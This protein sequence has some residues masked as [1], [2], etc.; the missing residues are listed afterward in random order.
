MAKQGISTG[1]TPNDGTGDSL[2]SGAVKINSNFDEIYTAIGDG[3]TLSPVT[4]IVAGDNISVSGSTG[5]VTITGIGTADIDTDKINV[6][7]ISTFGT[8]QISSGIVTAKSGI[9]TYYGDGSGLTGVAS[10]DY[11]ITGTAATFNNAVKVG[12][13]VTIDATSGIVTATSFSGSGIGLTGLPAGQLTGSLPAIDGSALTGVTAVGSGI[14]VRDSGTPIGAASTVDFGTGLSVSPVSS[15]IV[16]VTSSAGA[17][18]TANINSDTIVV[19]VLTATTFAGDLTLNTGDLLLSAGG[20]SAT[21][22]SENLNWGSGNFYFN[23]GTPELAWV[24]NSGNIRAGAGGAGSG[25]VSIK[26]GNPGENSGVFREGGA[27]ELYYDNSKKFET[28]G[29]GVTVLGT[30]DTQQLNVAGVSTFSGDIK[31]DGSNIVLGV[32]GGATDDRIVLGSSPGYLQIYNASGASSVIDGGSANIINKTPD[33]QVQN[34]G[35]DLMLQAANA[36]SVDLYYNGSKKFETTGAGVS[37]T[38][39][40]YA[41]GISTFIG[42]VIIGRT[43][44]EG[45]GM[46]LDGGGDDGGSINFTGPNS[47]DSNETYYPNISLNKSS[48]NFK[49]DLE[50][51]TNGYTGIGNGVGDFIF[52]KRETSSGRAERMRLEGETGNLTITGATGGGIC[53]ATSFYG[54]GS[55]LAD[56]RWTLGADGSSNYTFTG[57]GFTQTTNDPILYLARGRVYEFVNNSGGSHPFQIRESNGGSAYDNGVTNNGAA[58]GTIRFEIP[59]NAPNTLYYQCTSHSGMGNTISVYPNTI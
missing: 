16:T 25:V 29:T 33:F 11:I 8:V 27:A 7:G 17:A 37:I 58:S 5:N 50:F 35:G 39:N 45:S 41:T 52:Y 48:G 56:G 10:T 54:D 36:S 18:D 3:S 21:T 19:G 40:V 28:L 32:S 1:T 15:G 2:L 42:N 23:S 38:G 44:N 47:S 20:I 34:A 6:S 59:F 55:E 53:S 26:V 12:T 9:V 13:A 51:H 14:E 57:I 24:G 22:S 43:A 4:S 46:M 31:T 49:G 30:T